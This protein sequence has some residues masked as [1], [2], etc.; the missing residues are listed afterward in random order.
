[1]TEFSFNFL[2]VVLL[3]ISAKQVFTQSAPSVA[4]AA[5]ASREHQKSA[6]PKHVLTNDDFG[7][8]DGTEDS[9]DVATS[10]AQLRIQMEKSY[11]VNPTA[12]DLKSEMD[13]LGI[14]AKIPEGELLGK[15]KREALYG[16]EDVNFP[17]K[18]EWEQQLTT[19]VAH[20]IA[21]GTA[22]AS[23]IGAILEQSQG[24]LSNRDPAVVQKV[25][26]QWID[27]V[28]PHAV[29][30]ARMQHLIED[31]KTRI[32]AYLNNSEAAIGDY[33]HAREKQIESGIGRAMT[34]LR[35]EELNFKRSHGRYTCELTQFPNKQEDSKTWDSYMETVRLWGYDIFMQGCDTNHYAASAVPHAPDGTQGRAFCSSESSEVRIA[36]DGRAANCLSKGSSWHDE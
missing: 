11:P 35:N 9:E 14:Y 3:L 23:R 28:V 16:Y 15:F 13:R 6:K 10:A 25:R 32:K 19:A 22:A 26:T 7:Q 18:E 5:R 34:V 17:G 1:M 8:S 24:M 30:Q 36:E 31:G 29:W 21:E 12:A 2:V 33:R 4:D 20:F 27:A